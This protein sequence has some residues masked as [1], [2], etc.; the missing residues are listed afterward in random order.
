MYNM[1]QRLPPGIRRHLSGDLEG[2]GLH[3]QH[4]RRSGA[5]AAAQ[6]RRPGP[7]H[8]PW[9]WSCIFMEAQPIE[10]Q[11]IASFRGDGSGKCGSHPPPEP[12]VNTSAM[13][14][15]LLLQA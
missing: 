7:S 6:A 9:I 1:A 5:A 4:I 11:C 15:W 2:A 13:I 14:S 8:L 3:M 10:Q 12:C